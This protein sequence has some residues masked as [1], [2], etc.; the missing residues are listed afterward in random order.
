CARRQGQ[1]IRG[2]LI[3]VK[4]VVIG[5]EYCFLHVVLLLENEIC[6]ANVRALGSR[7]ADAMKAHVHTLILQRSGGGVS[8]AMRM[9]NGGN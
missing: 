1:F 9:V 6:T 3:Q 8:S 2:R 4:A 5:L 7:Q